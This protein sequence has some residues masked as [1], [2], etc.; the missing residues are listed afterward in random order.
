[1]SFDLSSHNTLRLT[2]QAETGHII[3][4]EKHLRRMLLES[5][6]QS[7]N[8]WILGGGSNVILQP[9]LK[10]QVLIIKTRG[11]SRPGIATKDG[12]RLVTIAAGE[13]WHQLVRYTVAQG[14][15]GLENLALIP[16][17]VGAAP[18]QNIGAYGVELSGLLHSLRAM[19][20]E[21]GETVLFDNAS[22]CFA[23]RDSIFKKINS[24]W[25]ILDI[26]LRLSSAPD[27]E[28]T[29][30]DVVRELDRRGAA[31][32]TGTEL[33]ECIIA[34]RR[35][36][37]PDVREYGNAGSFFKNPVVAKIKMQDVLSIRPD[38]PVYPHGKQFKLSAARLIDA[39]NL[40]A[41]NVGAF[42]VWQRQPLV[43]VNMGA[44][45]FEQLMQLSG[46]IQSEVMEKFGIALEREPGLLG[47]R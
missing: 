26:T 25:I 7:S 29:Y 16:G 2:A 39:S 9:R 22:C 24:P 44:G 14:L 47:S 42:G 34:I 23:Y 21:T 38:I 46:A 33:M 43:L 41:L 27:F 35:R 30:P 11:I 32:V 36:K 5:D 1:M 45:T 3:T 8:T 10:G 6:Y 31:K 4:D 19:H 28:L 40:K 17:S 12:S 37:M 20:R 18:V 13:N 15:H